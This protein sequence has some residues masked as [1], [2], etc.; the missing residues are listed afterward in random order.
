MRGCV[1]AGAS[2]AL[3]FLG[4]SDVFDIV[5]G[6]SAGSMTAAYFISRQFSAISI[7]Y[8]I[9][10]A[11]G[12]TFIDKR[13]LL[14]ALG[15]PPLLPTMK[16]NN[17]YIR[18][19]AGASPVSSSSTL[20]AMAASNSGWRRKP[21]SL[22]SSSR[23]AVTPAPSL[24][25]RGGGSSSADDGDNDEIRA[26][27]RSTDA[28]VFNLDFL[29]QRVMATLQPLDWDS[30]RSNERL[31]PLRIVTSSL[32][33]LQPL[34]LSW[35]KGHYRDLSSLL[36]CIRC[37]MGVPGITGDLMA[38]PLHPIQQHQQEHHQ[39]Q[40]H[41]S[42][43]RRQSQ[44]VPVAVSQRY[45][46]KDGKTASSYVPKHTRDPSRLYSNA[47]LSSSGSVSESRSEQNK[48]SDTVARSRSFTPFAS[49]RQAVRT[50]NKGSSSSSGSGSSD[51]NS[52]SYRDKG[53]SLPEWGVV[54]PG[55]S[56]YDAPRTD[57]AYEPLCDAFLC[58]P[59]PFRSAV[60]EE[61]HT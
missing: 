27:S 52:S 59:L 25:T 22:S 41:P 38:L 12:D 5:Y 26:V 16:N 53:G 33:T 2:A 29:L 57:T 31:Q 56:A 44:Q 39:H 1:S 30:F 35:E 6:S 10:P 32:L 42:P 23:S 34:C 3:N 8:D 17:R 11:A 19:F 51:M 46:Q 21:S 58:E 15:L 49:L 43:T 18:S 36:D 14:V 40:Q 20:S 13:K 48:D 50:R 60:R 45:Y 9:L 37:S 61:P 54:P 55:M 28:S 4:L 24:S 7:F 47:S